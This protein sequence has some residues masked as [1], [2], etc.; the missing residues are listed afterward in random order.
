ME[1]YRHKINHQS[2]KSIYHSVD[3]ADGKGQKGREVRRRGER[4][5]GSD[6]REGGRRGKRFM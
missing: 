4:R 5:E 6:R 2:G 1:G 3:G